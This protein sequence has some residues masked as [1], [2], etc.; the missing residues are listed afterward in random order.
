MRPIA[1]TLATSQTFPDRQEVAGALYWYNVVADLPNPPAPP[2]GPDGKPISPDALAPIFPG[3]IIEQEVSR[4]RWIP[5]P[6]P[7]RDIYRL[8]RPTPL[9]RALRLEEVLGTP[10]R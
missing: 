1:R 3:A 10:A 6:E 2:L 4:E 8:W 9:Y 5:I 7:V